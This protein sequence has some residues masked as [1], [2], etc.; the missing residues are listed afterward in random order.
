VRKPTPLA[1]S[2]AWHTQALRDGVEVLTEEPQCGWF[3]RRMVKGGPFVAAKIYL[4]QD[5]D[6]AGDLIDEE[7]LLCE[8]AGNFKDPQQEWL[9]LAKRPISE[10]DYEFMMADRRWCAD[11][12]PDQPAAQPFKPID[13]LTVA[14]PTFTRKPDD[15]TDA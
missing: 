1:I 3:K 9:S 5:V 12:A 13:W 14:P 4:R 6:D 15:E 11:N 2:H 10:S 7:I 8:V